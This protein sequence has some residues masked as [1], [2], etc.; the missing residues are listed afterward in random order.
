MRGFLLSTI[1]LTFVAALAAHLPATLDCTCRLAGGD[2]YTCDC[3]PRKQ[4]PPGTASLGTAIR[5]TDAVMKVDEA[6]RID[7]EAVEIAPESAQ[8]GI[9]IVRQ[10]ETAGEEGGGAVCRRAG[11]RLGRS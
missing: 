9:G 8:A 1:A 10:G 2:R 3:A 5:A 6:F 4:V 7:I 11:S